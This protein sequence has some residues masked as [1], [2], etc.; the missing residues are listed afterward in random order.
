MLSPRPSSPAE[1]WG[2][3]SWLVSYDGKFGPTGR[4]P[5]VECVGARVAAG[6]QLLELVDPSRVEVAIR[7][8]ASR[9]GEVGAGSA[10][11]LRLSDG[12]PVVWEGT[13]TR[14]APEVDESDRTFAVYCEVSAE[15]TSAP[16][17]PGAFVLAEVTGR[18]YDDVMPVP[19]TAFVE[20]SVY[21]AIPTESAGVA[22]VE[23]RHPTIYRM[24]PDVALVKSGLS[25]GEAVILTNLDQ[26]VEGVR[27]RTSIATANGGAP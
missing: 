5:H 18:S 9:Y 15:D 3:K 1:R 17:P 2:E 13:V 12:G 8:G 7:L 27:V 23:L 16:V 10:V 25:P 26:V 24:L 19:R 20:D 6:A 22:K 14:V 4:P 11:R 21:V